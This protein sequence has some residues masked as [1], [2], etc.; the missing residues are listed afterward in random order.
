MALLFASA[1]SERV[2]LSSAVYASTQNKAAL[3]FSCWTKPAANG[4]GNET[5]FSH[6]QG[7]G[8]TGGRFSLVRVGTT[9]EWRVYGRRLDAD[10]GTGV[11]GGTNSAVTGTL[12]HVAGRARFS[13]GGIDLWVNGVQLNTAADGGWTGNSSNTA[14]TVAT[15]GCATDISGFYNGT[16]DDVRLYSRALTDDELAM[17]YWSQGRDSILNGLE[18]RWLLREASEGTSASGAGSIFDIGPTLATGTPTNTPTYAAAL[19][20]A[21]RRR[22]VRV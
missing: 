4:A 15:I 7:G 19:V 14:S 18:Q 6:S 2:A 13:T 17:L 11:N 22:N 1:S 20:P 5:L 12:Y 8:G 21:A 16:I 3:T 9:D 10:S